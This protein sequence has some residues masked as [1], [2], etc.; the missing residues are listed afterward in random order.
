M[1]ASP[2]SLKQYGDLTIYYGLPV[3]GGLPA[4]VGKIQSL[5]QKASPPVNAKV[6]DNLGNTVSQV[7]STATDN[8][9]TA[10][11]LVLRSGA[12][13]NAGDLVS[14]TNM[15]GGETVQGVITDVSTDWNL[16]DAAKY[17]VTIESSSTVDYSTYQT[18]AADGNIITG[19]PA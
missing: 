10:S 17:S 3:P 12:K 16:N 19:V 5:S 8:Q 9:L 7:V 6:V 1:A 15:P 4:G 18:I 14:I 11:F 13:P 2:S